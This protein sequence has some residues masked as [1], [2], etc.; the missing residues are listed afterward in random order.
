MHWGPGGLTW[1]KPIT[2][3]GKKLRRQK[4]DQEPLGWGTGRGRGGWDR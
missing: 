3:V 2:E 4:V 1:R